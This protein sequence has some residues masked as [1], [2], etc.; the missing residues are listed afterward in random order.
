MKRTLS[1]RPPF[2]FRAVADSHG[3]RQL[4]PFSGDADGL[5]Y[6]T[7]L[8]SGR[9]T[10]LHL[11]AAPDGAQIESADALTDDEQAEIAMMAGW[12]LALDQDLSAFYAAAQHE[13]K[14]AQVAERAQGRLLRSPTLFED[15]VKTILTTNT[16]WTGTIRMVQA[17]VDLFGDPLDNVSSG[18]FRD[19]LSG[20]LSTEPV[21]RAFPLPKSI[22]QADVETLRQEAR[23]GYRA[24]YVLE[25]AQRVDS[26]ALDLE[27]LKTAELPTG[28]L[29]KRL[30]AIKGV[31]P[32][33]VANLLMLL[34]HYDAIPIDSWALTLVS[35]EWH[36]GAAIG[37]AEVEAAFAHWGQFKGLAYWFW[38][39]TATG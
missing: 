2:S 29:R 23:L 34:G 33:A 30:R 11:A 5:S 19:L 18:P 32:Y 16:T 25:L 3:W 24:P 31:G 14:L 27:A 17:L 21:R 8:S 20:P 9:V 37:P 38:D 6:I 10:V 36:G 1:A 22:A 13:S 15:V 26:G 28:E 4:A 7:R 35:K 12:M 39:W